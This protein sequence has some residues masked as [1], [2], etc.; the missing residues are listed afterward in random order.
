MV[1][2]EIKELRRKDYGKVIRFAINGMHF[3][4]YVNSKIELQLYGRYFLCL[5]LE[6][7]TQVVAAYEGDRLVGVLMA[8]MKNERKKHPSIWR[9][10]YVKLVDTVMSLAYKNGTA[11]YDAANAAMLK[12]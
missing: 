8:D 11:P 7:A 6:R 9:K 1:D 5:E 3:D 2:I 4:R 12:E 10:L